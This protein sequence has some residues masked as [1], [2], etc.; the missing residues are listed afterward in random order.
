MGNRICLGVLVLAGWVQAVS[1]P[2]ALE[3]TG[4]GLSRASVQWK[5]VPGASSYEVAFSTSADGIKGAE[6]IPVNARNSCEVTNL[7]SR[8]L[9]YFWVRAQGQD[10]EPSL[11]SP[12]TQARTFGYEP[13]KF[14]NEVIH[15]KHSLVFH[16]GSVGRELFHWQTNIPGLEWVALENGVSPARK[17]PEA[18][19]SLNAGLYSAIGNF[20][21]E[22]EV[23]LLA[24]EGN[25]VGFHLGGHRSAL[26]DHYGRNH[27]ILDPVRQKVMIGSVTKDSNVLNTISAS[28]P[29]SCEVGRTYKVRFTWDDS[30]H[31]LRAHIDGVE[32]LKTGYSVGGNA[33]WSTGMVVLG[34]TPA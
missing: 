14:Q 10:R 1:A 24:A 8:T 22:G 32:V 16:D 19:Y 33:I 25:G 4:L 27:L 3:A 23:T 15:W 34:G 26:W 18:Y 28:A 9:Y 11:W 7:K 30:D 21:V 13:A 31:R 5:T 20:Y 12:M 29:F 6:L 17:S 2:I